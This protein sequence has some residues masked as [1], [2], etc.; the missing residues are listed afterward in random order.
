MTDP[1]HEWADR[2]LM[3]EHDAHPERFVRYVV[4][5]KKTMNTEPND[6]GPAY[7]CAPTKWN[8]DGYFER[9]PMHSG[10][11]MTLR[12]YFAAAALQGIIGSIFCTPQV[13]Y[14]ECADRAYGM[15]DAML[16]ARES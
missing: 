15:A 2:E 10:M 13:T 14:K 6:G 12:D 9:D 5:P 3:D 4:Q 7:P 8:A 11:G 16:A 1:Y